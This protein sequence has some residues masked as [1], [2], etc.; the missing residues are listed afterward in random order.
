[1]AWSSGD[2]NHPTKGAPEEQGCCIVLP[3]V[4]SH[5]Y[6]HTHRGTASLITNVWGIALKNKCC[7]FLSGPGGTAVSITSHSR[8][9]AHSERSVWI[10]STLSVP[11]LQTGFKNVPDNR[12]TNS[13]FIS[14]S[15]AGLSMHI[16]CW[17]RIPPKQECSR[18][19]KRSKKGKRE[20][21]M[22]WEHAEKKGMKIFTF[23]VITEQALS[24]RIKKAFKCYISE[25][26]IP[27][28]CFMILWILTTIYV[29]KAFPSFRLFLKYLWDISSNFP[30]RLANLRLI[31]TY[32][33]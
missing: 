32:C 23:P 25:G 7:E 28:V 9:H 20:R 21:E 15:Q 33:K 26:L 5:P 6:T 4:S 27:Y 13:S 31:M 1:M 30:L 16:R 2:H 22:E 18:G 8:T 14:C 17:S 11:T 12:R 19:K 10:T 24:E 3:S 29:F